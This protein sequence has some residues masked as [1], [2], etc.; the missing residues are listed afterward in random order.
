MQ[1]NL[2]IIGFA[3]KNYS[4]Y[5][6]DLPGCI[7]VGD[8][9]E[10]VKNNIK[11]AVEL[12]VEGSLADGDPIPDSFKVPFQL[13]F[14]LT[15]SAYLNELNKVIPY[16]G[17]ERLTGIN[18]KQVQHYASGLKQP[19]PAQVKKIEDALHN[20]GKQLLEVQL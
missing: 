9:L 7:S 4:A 18:R 2:V 17:I 11:E 14:Q 20:L 13:E 8:S 3:E 16:A 1:T 5:L 19:R 12:H 10:E 6:P 15:V